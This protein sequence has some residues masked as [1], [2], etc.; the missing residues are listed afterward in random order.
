MT[1]PIV[2]CDDSSFARKQ[3]ARSLPGGW[4]V[5]VSFAAH[6]KEAIDAIKAGKADILFLDLNMPI[7]DGY[8]VLEA[9]RAEDL[10]TMVLVV[11]GDIQPEAHKRVTS[12]GALDFI[13][14][15]VT[16]EKITEILTNFGIISQ[17]QPQSE[18]ELARFDDQQVG[19]T[20]L[21]QEVVNV[22]MG[23]A[24]SLLAGLLDTFIHLPVPKIHLVEYQKL[25]QILA[26]RE[27]PS[28]S[29]VSQG[30]NGSGISGE[31]VLVVS[32]DS[33]PNMSKLLQYDTSL[34]GN[35]DLE[36]LMDLSGILIGACLKGIAE[37]LD[38]EFSYSHPMIL[39]RKQMLA[40]L[41]GDNVPQQQ[42]LAIEIDYSIPAYN[43]ECDLI[44]ILTADSIP[45][46]SERAGYLK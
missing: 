45:A 46:L 17:T 2:I 43:V 13:K 29:G 8:E 18:S 37:Q 22:S 23:Q 10:P 39:G 15:P 41:L 36:V 34:N 44:L 9:I 21:I 38:L 5:E 26:S 30:F 27:N 33:V 20:D 1:T 19:L 42:V 31:A 11:S 40:P 4:D 3:M 16:T 28:L 25:S 32:D 14:K 35:S 24:G 6:E 12:L 7:M